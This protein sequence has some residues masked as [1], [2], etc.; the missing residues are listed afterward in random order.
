IGLPSSGIHSNG[1]SLVRKII[2]NLDL[3]KT[4]EGLSRPLG[5]AL[6]APTK[7]YA[8][9]LA[10]VMKEATI[11]G[12]SHITGGGFYENFPRMLPDG[13]GVQL[14]RSSWH[15]PEIFHLLQEKGNIPDREMLSVFNM[16]IGMALVGD[17][18]GAARVL[19]I[20]PQY[21]QDAAII[22]CV[23]STRG[24]HISPRVM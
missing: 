22:G 4:Y 2:E 14:E 5:E 21:D 16:G 23:T 9:A 24:V 8:K 19:S 13:L 3:D 20:L 7:I 11:K 15:V 1:Y 10:A 6:L 18:R 12:V 17:E